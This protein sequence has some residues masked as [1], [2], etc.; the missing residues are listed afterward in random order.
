MVAVIATATIGDTTH[1]ARR[2]I[3]AVDYDTPGD[4]RA[5]ARILARCDLEDTIRA[6]HPQLSIRAA[7]DSAMFAEITTERYTAVREDTHSR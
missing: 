5:Q 1:T 4:T 7:F 6:A 2:D 3:P